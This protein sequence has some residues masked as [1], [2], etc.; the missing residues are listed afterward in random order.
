MRPVPFCVAPHRWKRNGN[1]FAIGVSDP[2]TE[3]GDTVDL[4]GAV[5]RYVLFLLRHKYLPFLALCIGIS[6]LPE[7]SVV[8]K[9]A[10]RHENRARNFLLAL[11]AYILIYEASHSEKA[12]VIA[13]T[14]SSGRL[15]FTLA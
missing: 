11:S 9:G 8:R 2:G 14:T 4:G 1:P 5:C 7:I 3:I 15:Y 10:N 6:V 13:F 12:L